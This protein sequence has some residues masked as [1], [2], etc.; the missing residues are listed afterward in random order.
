MIDFNCGSRRYAHG[1]TDVFFIDGFYRLDLVAEVID[2]IAL[3][4]DDE[5]E[6]EESVLSWHVLCERFA[7]GCGLIPGGAVT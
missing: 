5:E 7:P 1:A 3:Y 4:G 6:A 2:L